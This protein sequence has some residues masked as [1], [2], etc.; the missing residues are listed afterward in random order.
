[1][2]SWLLYDPEAALD[3]FGGRDGFEGF[4]KTERIETYF[5][6][7]YGAWFRNDYDS[8]VFNFRAAAR[9]KPNDPFVDISLALVLLKQGSAD[10]APAVANCF[11]QYANHP[12]L[13]LVGGMF[14][15][16][17]PQIGELALAYQEKG[18][19]E[20]AEPLYR[21]FVELA[22]LEFGENDP[23]YATCL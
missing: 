10:T 5:T 9:I 16:V 8:A 14:T 12:L 6:K 23:S 3:A 18:E 17:G 20:T 7:G 19:Y 21:G 2:N 4:M 15:A 11:K 13:K 1:A 22:R